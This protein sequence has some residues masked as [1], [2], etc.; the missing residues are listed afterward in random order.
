MGSFG[1]PALTE[2]TC[3]IVS[4]VCK[5]DNVMRNVGLLKNRACTQL[6][7]SAKR[8]RSGKGAL[9]PVLTNAFG[10]RGREPSY[11]GP[12]AQIRASRIPALGSY[13]GCLTANRT[14][15]QGCRIRGLGRNSS[16]SFAIRV[17]ATCALWLRRQSCQCQRRT[18][19]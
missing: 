16:T 9:A 4:L 19:W 15:G 5:V 14:L 18:T 11:P 17:Q 3:L 12:P 7:F 8:V 1:L 13:L 6:P 2:G 10:D